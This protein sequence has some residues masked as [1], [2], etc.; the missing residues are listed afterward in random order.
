MRDAQEAVLMQAVEQVAERVVRCGVGLRP[1]R[2]GV[3][4][5]GHRGFSGGC[6][7]ERRAKRINGGAEE[8]EPGRADE[9][10]IVAQVVRR[11]QHMLTAD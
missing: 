3:E 1:R 8:R 2:V 11:A 6:R 10:R 9:R 7:V 4:R 5:I